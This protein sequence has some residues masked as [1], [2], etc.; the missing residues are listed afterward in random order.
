MLR[1]TSKMHAIEVSVT[2]SMCDV[3]DTGTVMHVTQVS[4]THVVQ[5][6]VTHVVQ[7]ALMHVVQVALMHVVQVTCDACDTGY[8]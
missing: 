6:S 3:C 4:V 2:R 8:L 5:V 1:A 7:V